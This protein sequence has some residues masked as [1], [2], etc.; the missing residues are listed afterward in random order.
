MHS[1]ILLAPHCLHTSILTFD[2]ALN[3]GQPA[4]SVKS[5]RSYPI[6]RACGRSYCISYQH[7]GGAYT[8]NRLLWLWT[9]TDPPSLDKVTLV[10]PEGRLLIVTCDLP[11]QRGKTENEELH[12]IILLFLDILLKLVHTNEH[13]VSNGN[14]IS[15][16][17][18]SFHQ[19]YLLIL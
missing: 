13:F 12:L 6:I 3:K 11:S 19:H 15:H 14:P 2:L 7:E 1:A 17:P 8:M 9:R 5:G 18:K 4:L 10:S 16:I